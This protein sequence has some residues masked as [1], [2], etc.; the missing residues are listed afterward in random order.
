[1]GLV[2][3]AELSARLDY[4]SP[5]LVEKVHDLLSTIGLPTRFPDGLGAK[6]LIEAMGR[7]K[8]KAAG[9][10]RFV[11]LRQVGEAFVSDD[12]PQTA[13]VET[14]AALGARA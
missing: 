3:A 9:M 13:L 14:L 12:V 6:A 7:D 2:A 11:L 8:K 1:M 4:A 10:L 5:S